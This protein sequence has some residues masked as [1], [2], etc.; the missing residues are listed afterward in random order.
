MNI[1]VYTLKIIEWK[2]FQP[3]EWTLFIGSLL[4]FIIIV[5]IFVVKIPGHKKFKEMIEQQEKEK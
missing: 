3:Y 4:I 5:L 2:Q 1:L